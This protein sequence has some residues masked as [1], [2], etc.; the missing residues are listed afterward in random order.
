MQEA[1]VR[2]PMQPPTISII[3]PSQGRP[4]LE[5]TLDSVRDQ[6]LP[7]DEVWVIVDTHEMPLADFSAIAER[8]R[9]YGPQFRITGHDAGCH[10]HGHPQINFGMACVG[11]G[12]DNDRVG[13]YLSFQ[14]D[15]DVYTPG[16]LA[17]MREAAIAHPG[18]PLLFRFRSYLGG[19]VFWRFAGLVAEA[20]IG[21]HC[22]VFPN[23][24]AHL[25]KWGD[26]YEGDFTFIR[27]SL[28]SWAT[29]GVTPVW[30]DFVIAVARPQEAA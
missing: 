9:P 25:G 20:T 5:R 26:H 13:D 28:D 18:R 3:I 29:A 24:P 21:G 23:D 16:A 11:G 2:E 1:A 19:L 22:A 6:L 27:D 8:M 10:A 7:G 30:C 15:D 14:D 4:T 12:P 17:A